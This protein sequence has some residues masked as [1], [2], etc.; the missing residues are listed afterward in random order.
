MRILISIEIFIESRQRVLAKLHNDP[1]IL[2]ENDLPKMYEIKNCY[3]ANKI[4]HYS[5]ARAVSLS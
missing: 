4:N 2:F 3:H 1:Y 5:V